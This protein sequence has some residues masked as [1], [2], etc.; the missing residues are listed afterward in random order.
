MNYNDDDTQ[1]LD[2]DNDDD[3]STVRGVKGGR[4]RSKTDNS[5]STDTVP[6]SNL[7]DVDKTRG[8]RKSRE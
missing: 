1:T 8:G 5:D 3:I 4:A 7:A 6:G 2:R